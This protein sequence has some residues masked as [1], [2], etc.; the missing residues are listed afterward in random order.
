MEPMASADRNERASL[1]EALLD[2]PHSWEFFQVVRILE[3]AAAE[4]MGVGLG[5]DP[6]REAVRFRADPRLSFPAYEVTRVE[7]EQD[8]DPYEVTVSFLGLVGTQGPLPRADTERVLRRLQR[9][10]RGLADFLDLFHHRLVSLFYRARQK[11]RAALRIQPPE[12]SPMAAALF[13]SMGLGW[14]ELRKAAPL[15]ERALLGHAALLANRQRSAVG[16]ERMLRRYFGVPVRVAQFVGA[17]RAIEPGD[18]TAIGLGGRHRTLGRDAMVGARMWQQDGTIEVE[19]G[20]LSLEQFREFLPGGSRLQAAFELVELYVRDACDVR[21]RPV[22][23]AEE[24]PRLRLGGEDARL[25]WS[26]WLGG[27]PPRTAA[28]RDVVLSKAQHLRRARGATAPASSAAPAPAG[29]G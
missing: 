7:R 9:R 11:H 1:V 19:F 16:L 13:A 15:P 25:G 14:P 18:R 6:E 27:E 2:D 20:P 5:P 28:A 10:D 3:R 23:A 17:W 22:L 4:R 26:T 21:L 8:D 29:A 24:V 12:R